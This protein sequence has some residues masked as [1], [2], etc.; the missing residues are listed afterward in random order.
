MAPYLSAIQHVQTIKFSFSNQKNNKLWKSYTS[1]N[2][3]VKLV[4][5][6]SHLDSRPSFS[7]NL[8]WSK[9]T[10]NTLVMASWTMF[11]S[12]AILKLSALLLETQKWDK[13]TEHVDASQPYTQRN[14]RKGKITRI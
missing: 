12:D 7:C 2:I 10:T 14:E 6:V 13:G 9:H 8:R 11:K 4:N 3:L 5:I 1:G